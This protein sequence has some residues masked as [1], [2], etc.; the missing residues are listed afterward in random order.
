ML[1]FIKCL[2]NCFQIKKVRLGGGIGSPRK[3]KAYYHKPQK[4][5]IMYDTQFDD[6]GEEAYV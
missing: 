5:P 3:Y 2:L 6:D 4:I 1:F